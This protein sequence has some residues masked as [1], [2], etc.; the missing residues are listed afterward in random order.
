MNNPHLFT[1]C[2]IKVYSKSDVVL[3]IDKVH[4]TNQSFKVWPKAHAPPPLF[5]HPPTTM[6][7]PNAKNHLAQVDW[8]PQAAT[9]FTMQPNLL[10]Y[11]A[12]LRQNHKKRQT[13]LHKAQGDWQQPQATTIFISTYRNHEEWLR[14]VPRIGNTIGKLGYHPHTG[15]YEFPHLYTSRQPLVA[16]CFGSVAQCVLAH[17]YKK[18]SP[19]GKMMSQ[20]PRVN[21]GVQDKPLPME[22]S[23]QDP[24]VAILRELPL[25]NCIATLVGLHVVSQKMR[26]QIGNEVSQGIQ[27]NCGF[28]LCRDGSLGN[29]LLDEFKGW[30][31]TYSLPRGLPDLVSPSGTVIPPADFNSLVTQ[32]GERRLPG[33]NY[34]S[35]GAAIAQPLIYGDLEKLVKAGIE[36]RREELLQFGGK[37]RLTGLPGHGWLQKAANVQPFTR[38][39]WCRWDQAHWPWMTTV[40]PQQADDVQPLVVIDK[41]LHI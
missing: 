14:Q 1:N 13:N 29:I 7:L 8:Q 26:S 25:A 11:G 3:I 28:K 39:C 37:S 32:G 12:Q 5:P 38:S 15:T 19:G 18:A 23:E 21:C 35:L 2:I 30:S 22:V 10:S 20:T 9:K 27:Q 31:L 17:C 16:Q 33:F 24:W 6:K 40:G 4:S 41:K 36:A 34:P